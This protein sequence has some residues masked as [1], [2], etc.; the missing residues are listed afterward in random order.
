MSTQLLDAIRQLNLKSGDEVELNV[1]GLPVTI[2]AGATAEPSV[3]AGQVM[4]L[5][6]FDSPRQPA[7]IAK[8]VP[9]KLS[10]PDPVVV[11]ND[12]QEGP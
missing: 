6:W 12:E 4:L 10:P 7:G 3:Y 2:R 11:P 1:D 9:G 8:A 5:P